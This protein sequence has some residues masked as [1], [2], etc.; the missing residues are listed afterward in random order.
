MLH[1]HAS[2]FCFAFVC[3][4]A[5]IINSFGKFTLPKRWFRIYQH[6]F[7]FIYGGANGRREMN[8]NMSVRH[9]KY[10]KWYFSSFWWHSHL[11]WPRLFVFRC[12]FVPCVAPFSLYF[13]KS[14]A[15]RWFIITI[16]DLLR[17]VLLVNI[18]HDRAT[19]IQSSGRDTHWMSEAT[20]GHSVESSRSNAYIV[21]IVRLHSERLIHH[22][23][24]ILSVNVVYKSLLCSKCRGPLPILFGVN[25]IKTCVCAIA[26]RQYIKQCGVAS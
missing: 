1:T 15:F 5:T 17:P 20:I 12:E 22:H 10:P 25:Y 11:N 23:R 18:D 16:H 26:I 21:H 9:N 24:A 13:W 8:T 6:I 3:S 2:W 4:C 7:W 14:S 19:H